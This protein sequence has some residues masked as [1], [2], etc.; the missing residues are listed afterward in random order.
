MCGSRA[1]ART[2]PQRAVMKKGYG[3]CE[4]TMRGT[5]SHST[6]PPSACLSSTFFDFIR[7][8]AR[9]GRPV[10]PG[11]MRRIVRGEEAIKWDNQ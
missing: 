11:V 7:A 5:T 4:L 2:P 8:V 10:N 1:C 3:T 9:V 6:L